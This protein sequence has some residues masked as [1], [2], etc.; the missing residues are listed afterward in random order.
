MK[1]TAIKAQVKSENRVSIFVDG[2]Y[3]FSLTLDQLL[4]QRLKKGDELDSPS[5]QRLK[6]LSDEGKMKAKA[7]DW[8]MIRP[9][10]VREF[11]DY[12]YRKKV[13]SELID[14]WVEDFKTKKYLN[15][16]YFAEWFATGRR[17]K[18]KSDRAIS[19]E[20]YSKGIDKKSI[21]FALSSL[22]NEESEDGEGS[23]LQKLLQKYAGRPRYSDEKKL[24]SFL[25]GRGFSYSNIKDAI[26]IFNESK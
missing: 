23:A 4:E 26:K 21:E 12:L 15:D 17:A 18:N 6:K 14:I 10:S 20:L 9:H 2:V 25:I 3:S 8:L 1:I 16:E 11:R 7:I 13:E 22:V 19:S 24:I 5:I